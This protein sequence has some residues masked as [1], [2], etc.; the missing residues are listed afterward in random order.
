MLGQIISIHAP[1]TGRDFR[2]IVLTILN[3]DFNPRAPYGARLQRMGWLPFDRFISIHAPHTGRDLLPLAA[4]SVMRVNFNPRA[5]YGA[6]QFMVVKADNDVL[7]Q[8]TRPIRGAT[9]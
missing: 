2:I 3:I 6:R 8:S 4:L 9:D 5:P 7:F 1:H